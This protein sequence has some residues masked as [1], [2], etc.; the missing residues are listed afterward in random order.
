VHRG[1]PQGQ[2]SDEGGSKGLNCLAYEPMKVWSTASW[3][4]VEV[5]R[6][7]KRGRRVFRPHSSFSMAVA[8]D[9]SGWFFS[10]GGWDIAY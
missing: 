9:H 5:V 6:R 8:A 3:S 7:E 4:V 2:R 1:C 10:E